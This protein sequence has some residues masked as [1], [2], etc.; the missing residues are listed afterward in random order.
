M[1]EIALYVTP[2]AGVDDLE[3]KAVADA[4]DAQ[5]R[6]DVAPTLGMVA[7]PVKF[8]E[9]PRAIP[10]SA[11]AL[12][13]GKTAGNVKDALAWHTENAN[14]RIVGLIGVQTCKADGVSW[15]SAASHEGIEGF[16]NPYVDGFVVMPAARGILRLVAD[17]RC[18]P[19]Q[20]VT[21]QKGGVEVS[22]FVRNEW[23]DPH[24]RTVVD[25]KGAITIP[26]TKTDGGYFEVIQAGANG[27]HVIQM[28]E[29]R[30]SRHVRI[31]HTAAG[32][33]AWSEHLPRVAGWG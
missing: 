23:F 8:Y 26:F 17:E 2:D 29:K 25:F 13:A 18:D 16:V 11:F 3:G 1:N 15:S 28:G 31:E 21:Y 6:E 33:R 12:Q 7:I 14:G 30:H 19:V 4:L 22:D 27:W 5:I 20:D 10:A 32:P 9:D 24:A